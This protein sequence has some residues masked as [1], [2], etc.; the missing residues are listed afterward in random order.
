MTRL[1][2]RER[3]KRIPLAVRAYGQ[4]LERLAAAWRRALPATQIVVITGSAG[5]TTAKELLGA[6]LRRQGSSFSSFDTMN[7][8]WGLSKSVLGVRPWHRYAVLEVAARPARHSPRLFAALEPDMA[9]VLGVADLHTPMYASIEETAAAKEEV[10]AMLR[11]GGVAV[12]NAADPRVAAMAG[13]TQRRTVLFGV[14]GPRCLHATDV[15]SSWPD[16]LGFTLRGDG[17]GLPV[18]TRLVGEHWLPALLAALTAA[19]E[20]GVPLRQAIAAVEAVAPHRCRMQPVR[21]PSGAHIVRDGFNGSLAT[22]KAALKVLREARGARRWIVV[23]NVSDTRL[24]SHA[25]SRLLGK[26]VAE[27]VDQAVFVGPI[28][29]EACKAARRSGLPAERAR[30]FVDWRDAAEHLRRNLGP[31][32]LVLLRGCNSDK[33]ERLY[34]AQFGDVACRR[35]RCPRLYLCDHCQ[36]LGF[37]GRIPPEAGPNTGWEPRYGGDPPRQGAR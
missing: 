25:R 17:P 30:L 19:R 16:R 26:L 4:A 27:A 24:G 35:Q 20:L 23:S 37:A 22:L 5:K 14:P 29:A 1:R 13:R 11:P 18:R 33:I 36:D 6:I 34:F 32:D 8:G 15:G 7:T 9:V 10:L 3:L 31:D 21:L 12:L 2:L 28:G